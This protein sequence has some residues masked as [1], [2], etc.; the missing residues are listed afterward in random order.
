[1]SVKLNSDDCFM[2]QDD[3]VANLEALIRE[4]RDLMR[5]ALDDVCGQLSHDAEDWIIRAMD[6]CSQSQSK[7]GE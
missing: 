3:Y 1:M 7:G 6:L 5:E 4:A 2:T